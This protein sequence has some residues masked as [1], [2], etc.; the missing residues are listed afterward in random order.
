MLYGGMSYLV[1]WFAV[2]GCC[3]VGC[4]ILSLGFQYVLPLELITEENFPKWMSVFQAV[5]DRP[6]PQV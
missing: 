5:V 2:V 4:L 3:M 1:T 6:V